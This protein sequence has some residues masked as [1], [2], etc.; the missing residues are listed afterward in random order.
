MPHN[1]NGRHRSGGLLA[2]LEYRGVKRSLCEV[3]CPR[4]VQEKIKKRGSED[5]KKE[6]PCRLPETQ[7]G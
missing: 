6:D 2:L 1:S 4:W 5:Q 7:G 3:P